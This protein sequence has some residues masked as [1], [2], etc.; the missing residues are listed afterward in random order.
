MKKSIISLLIVAVV[1]ISSLFIYKQ[2]H[3]TTFSLS[4]LGKDVTVTA[5][6]NKDFTVYLAGPIIV[7]GTNF[8]AS[9]ISFTVDPKSK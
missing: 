7:N 9:N 5:V 1:V 8:P 4:D 3:R 6:S 2:T